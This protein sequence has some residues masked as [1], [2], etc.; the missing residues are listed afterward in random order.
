MSTAP[1]VLMLP[2]ENEN[3]TFHTFIMQ[4][5]NITRCIKHGVKHKVH[6]VQRKQTDSHKVVGLCLKCPPLTRT[7]ARKRVCH[8]STASSI[9]DCSNSHATHSVRWIMPSG[10]SFS[11]M[12]CIIGL[13]KECIIKVWNVMLSFS[14]GSVSTLN[15]WSGNFC[16]ICVKH[17]FLFTAVQKL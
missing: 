2:S 16:H 4:S 5:L 13:F 10:L 3:I 14:L 1:Y 12:Q 6:Q 15:R 9:S 8:W 11:L 17:F 7:Q